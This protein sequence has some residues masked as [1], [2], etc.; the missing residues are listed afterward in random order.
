MYYFAPVWIDKDFVYLRIALVLLADLYMN[1]I[2]RS[3]ESEAK[4]GQICTFQ[5]TET[6]RRV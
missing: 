1:I 4:A 2:Y 3:V 6:P 5:H